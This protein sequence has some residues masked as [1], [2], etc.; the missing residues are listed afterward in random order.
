MII[1]Q[2]RRIFFL[3]SLLIIQFLGTYS[4]AQ[5]INLDEKRYLKWSSTIELSWDDFWRKTHKTAREQKGNTRAAALVATG[6]SW[7]MQVNTKEG[8]VTFFAPAFLDR[9]ESWTRYNRKN[10]AADTV[11]SNHILNH[12]LGHFNITE[13]YAREGRKLLSEIKANSFEKAGKAFDQITKTI[14]R[15]WKKEQERYDRET[16]HGIDKEKQAEWDTQ[17]AQRLQELEKFCEK[18][19]VVK[20][21]EFDIKLSPDK[22][23]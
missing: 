20:L 2:S 6:V 16:Q 7:S 1:A 17:I 19:V 11:Q 15:K 13:I 9:K 5:K 22:E 18:E 12:E 14:D 23:R 3:F 21:R 4:Y 10:T 8:T